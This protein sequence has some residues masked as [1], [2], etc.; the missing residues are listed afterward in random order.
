MIKKFL[1]SL[2]IVVVASISHAQFYKSLLASP[3]FSNTLEKIVLDFRLNFKT[4]QGDSLDS[5]GE[6]ETY[7]SL[8]R[9]PGAKECLIY[10]FHS[11][12]DTTAS[13]QALMYTGDDYKEALRTY[14]DVVRLVKK[15]HVKWIDKTM[16]GFTGDLENPRQNTRFAVSTLTFDLDDA[17]YKKFVAEVELVDNYNGW[18]V[19]LNLQTKKP[20]SEG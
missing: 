13:W 7:E 11:V 2:V 9:L 4:I 10:Y 15:S 20:D 3:D 18:S 6:T 8:V 14:Q 1:L 17:R 19:H 5:N 16:V 12:Q